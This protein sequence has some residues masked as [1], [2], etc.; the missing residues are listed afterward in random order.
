VDLLIG[1]GC[2]EAIETSAVSSANLGQRRA[3]CDRRG[4]A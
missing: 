4:D 2:I 3:G 1:A